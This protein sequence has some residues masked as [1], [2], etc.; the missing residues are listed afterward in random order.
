MKNWNEK[1]LLL[2]LDFIKN[3]ELVNKDQ[4][5]K[6]LQV[7]TCQFDS[8]ASDFRSIMRDIKSTRGSRLM[9]S[10]LKKNRDNQ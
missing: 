7:D 5:M 2:V 4:L 9:K 10:L 6:K 1:E 8:K 3:H